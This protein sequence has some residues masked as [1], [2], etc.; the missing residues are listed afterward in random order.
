VG[1]CNKI[2]HLISLWCWYWRWNRLFG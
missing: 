1:Y 2:K